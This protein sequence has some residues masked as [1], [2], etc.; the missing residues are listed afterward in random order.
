MTKPRTKQSASPQAAI[1][2]SSGNVF[3]DLGLPNA[4]ER[5]AK[6]LLSRVI[7]DIVQQRGWTQARAARETGLAASDMSDIMRGKLAKFSRERLESIILDLDMDIH[8]RV[9]PKAPHFVRGQIAVEL[10]P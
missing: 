7:Q 8:M 9:T 6:A 2:A 5:L 1:T 3:A 4:E 10:A